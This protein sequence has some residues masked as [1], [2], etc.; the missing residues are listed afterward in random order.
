MQFKFLIPKHLKP[1]INFQLMFPSFERDL[2]F[3]SDEI[4]EAC[5]I[6]LIYCNIAKFTLEMV[7][8]WLH[9]KSLIYAH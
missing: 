5:F 8:L 9:I 6:S 1:G 4:Y 7:R 3:N 2:Y